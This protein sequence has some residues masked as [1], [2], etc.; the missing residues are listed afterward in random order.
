MVGTPGTCPEWSN[1]MKKIRHKMLTVT[2]TATAFVCLATSTLA[3]KIGPASV[4]DIPTPNG[5][6]VL[7]EL[8]ENEPPIQ[9]GL[10]AIDFGLPPTLV[11]PTAIDTGPGGVVHVYDVAAGELIPSFELKQ[12]GPS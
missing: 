2:L 10:R 6:F 3:M 1:T 9:V 11:P 5:E 8:T 4:W 7:N 12:G